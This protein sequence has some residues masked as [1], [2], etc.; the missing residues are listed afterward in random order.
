[1]AVRRDINIEEFAALLEQRRREMVEDVQR[2]L[3]KHEDQRFRDLLIPPGGDAGDRSVADVLVNL[4]LAEIDRDVEELRA[5]EYALARIGAGSYGICQ[6]CGSAIDEQRLRAIPETPL[7]IECQTR[8]EEQR[9][10][11]TPSL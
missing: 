2:E 4:N 6:S 5:I 8:L 10:T 11:R 1:M 9:V 7:C 3:E